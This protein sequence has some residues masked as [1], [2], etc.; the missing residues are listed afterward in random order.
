MSDY[1]VV[2][3]ISHLPLRRDLLV[4]YLHIVQDKYKF[5]SKDSMQQIASLL[6]ISLSEVYE[7]AS[8]YH[9]FKIMQKE[10]LPQEKTIIQVCSSLAC[11]LSDCDKL[12][13]ELK[14]KYK[15]NLRIEKVACLGRCKDAPASI[16]GDNDIAKADI[17]KIDLALQNKQFS[18]KKID[19]Y[20]DYKSYLS[21]DGYQ[22]LIDCINKLK[23]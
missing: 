4:E 21:K 12:Y 23:M 7:T 14:S 13:D 5:I 20:I 6:N 1:T 17:S 15:D 2:E 19:D 11:N 10:N 18:A 3:L 16:V 22:T 9:H 8:F